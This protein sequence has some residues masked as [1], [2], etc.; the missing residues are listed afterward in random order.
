LNFL[1]LDLVTEFRDL[2]PQTWEERRRVCSAQVIVVGE[3]LEKVTA[4]RGETDEAR[5]G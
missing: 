5:F 1:S 4:A 2:F 3:A